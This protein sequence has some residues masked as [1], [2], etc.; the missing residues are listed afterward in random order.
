MM[1]DR[2][3]LQLLP[4]LDDSGPAQVAIALG[5]KLMDLGWDVRIGTLSAA[6]PC[7]E[8][9][10]RGL[11]LEV[12][13]FRMTSFLDFHVTRSLIS[14]LRNER[15]EV[16]H[17]HGLRPDIY[18]GY[19]GHRISV[20]LIASTVH[21]NLTQELKLD[22]GPISAWGQVVVRRLTSRFF[23]HT[24]A[25]VS[26]DG[27]RALKRLGFGRNDKCLTVVHNGIILEDFAGEQ[28][29]VGEQVGVSKVQPVEIGTISV[30]NQRKD[31]A[32]LIGSMP[33]ILDLYPGAKL[34]VVGTG[35]LRS[36][37]Q[38][39]ACTLGVSDHVRFVGR[40]PRQEV[41]GFLRGLDV[42][43]LSSL[44]EG[45]PIVVLEAMACGVPVVA[46]RV[47]GIPEVI[48]DGETGLLVNPRDSVAIA[49][50]VVRILGDRDLACRL[51]KLA[52]EHIRAGF[53]AEH[54]AAQYD[55]LYRDGL[56]S[57]NRSS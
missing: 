7:T 14:Y 38:Q 24:I 31:V 26:Y 3:V 44:T 8:A 11:G 55:R 43:V 57:Q 39:V 45:I 54:M 56:T 28:Q 22:Y 21:G 10:V 13:D 15:I 23:H 41:I 19:S 46:T 6:S 25:A 34:S 18:G 51:S 50:A 9:Y 36:H 53:S 16:L 29:V 20:K 27:L 32:T 47:G 42:F 35:P 17:L 49:D 12:A 5:Y 48:S 2:R 33:K 1:P 52:N 40:L 30:L 4:R 37:L